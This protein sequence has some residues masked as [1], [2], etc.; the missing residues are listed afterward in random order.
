MLSGIYSRSH[1]MRTLWPHSTKSREMIYFLHHFTESKMLTINSANQSNFKSGEY[2]TVQATSA[3][4]W[5]AMGE[6]AFSDGNLQEARRCFEKALA[7]APFDAK[8]HNNLSVVHWQQGQ[9][10]DALNSLTRA[11]EL[12]PDDQDVIMNCSKIFQS[13]GKK[14]DAREILEAYLTRKPWDHEVKREM[15]NLDKPSSLIQPFDAAIFLNEQGEQQ[16]E[17]GKLDH[18]RACFEM[19]IE[20]D[21]NHAKAHSNLGVVY[22]RQGDLTKALEHLYLALDI[23]SEDPDIL[24]N[25]SSALT[26]AGEL[27]AAADLLRIYLQRNPLDEAAWEEYA[28]LL[29]RSRVNAWK[30]DGLTSEVADVYAQMGEKL[31]QSKDYTGASEAFQRALALAPDQTDMFYLLGRLHLEQDQ[32]TEALDI[33]REGLGKGESDKKIVLAMGEILASLEHR[34]DARVLYEDYLGENE[35]EDVRKALDKLS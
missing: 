25:S 5:V 31:A 32:K 20:Y 4:D 6:S 10:E 14:D 35:D 26:A 3:K 19:A 34:E 23:D 15:E 1:W 22:W 29:S 27:S 18:A 13:L 11:L 17:A 33:M 21:L 9:A 16:F 28:S 2:Q 12:D 8:V 24:Y 7:W 30:P